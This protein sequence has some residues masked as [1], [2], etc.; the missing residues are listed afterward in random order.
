MILTE[1]CSLTRTRQLPQLV[2][3]QLRSKSHNAPAASTTVLSAADFPILLAKEQRERCME[4]LRKLPAF[5]RP[6]SLTPNRHEKNS[7]SVLIALCLER[8]TN[9]ISLLYTRRSR[10]LRRHSLQISFPGGKRDETDTSFVDCALRETEEEIGL[11]RERI[12]IWGEA[13]PI[14][15]P[16]TA[17]IVPVVGVVPDFHVSQLKLN[18]DEVEEAFS[19]PLN[20]LLTPSAARHTQFRTGYSGPVF[21]VDQHRIWGITGYLTYMFLRCL[22]PS[23]MLPST[24]KTN[25]KFIRPYKVPPKLPHH[26]VEAKVE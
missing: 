4:K 18:W 25:I 9:E 22:L 7:A 11:P 2:C 5:P 20:S 23:S 17:T 26:H 8:D 16:R 6:K 10:H 15:L 1:I 21:V 14:D 3:R 19:I 13:N 12:Q 24:L